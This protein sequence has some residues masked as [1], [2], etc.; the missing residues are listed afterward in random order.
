MRAAVAERYGPPEVV[1]IVEMPMPA[2]R[3]REVLV[4]VRSVAVTV[5]DARVRGSRY[6]RGFTPFARAAFGILRPRRPVL[7]MAFSGTI[8]AVG[9]EVQ[10]F[11]VGDAVAGMTGF[12]M[13][14]HAE[15]VAVAATKVVPKPAG[16]SH[17]EA[18]AVLFGG[19]TAL[20]YLRDK[21]AVQP[22]ATVLVNG[23]SGAVGSA[24]VQ[25]AKHLGA[26]VTAVTSTANVELVRKLGADEVV[27]YTATPAAELTTK[28]DVVMDAVGNIG[29]AAGRRL[30]TEHGVLLL[31]VADF[32]DLL[33]ARGNAKAGTPPER[34]EDFAE[35]LGLVA[36][37]HLTA[38]IDDAVAEDGLEALVAAHARV[39]SGRKVGD[40][41]I[42]P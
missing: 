2:P 34:A 20:A 5:A 12:G 11:S 4:R 31:V 10:G 18:A 39:D 6:P 22:G 38:V 16:V 15:Y 26:T 23:A 9:S 13:G 14:A 35:L 7:G 19:S 33:R 25:L 37:G 36:D 32:W 30:L 41:V 8:E 1:R 40:L 3:R 21:A 42:H 28:Y 27:D 29:L 17:D 24:A